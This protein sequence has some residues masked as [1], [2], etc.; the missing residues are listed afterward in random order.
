MSKR[1]KISDYKDII[2]IPMEYKEYLPT[3]FDIIGKII[4]IKLKSETNK[5][6]K[7]IAEALLKTHKNIKSVCKISSVTGELRTRNIEI[8]G[9]ENS[10]ETIHKEYGINY[11]L[12]IKKTYFSPRLANERKRIM[13]LVKEN[14][15][16]IDMFTGVAPFSITI[17]KFAKPKIIYA[18]DKNPDAILYAKK[19]ITKNKLLHK[20]ELIK[21]DS[22][23][24]V[25]ILKNRNFEEKADRIIMNLPFSAYK[26]FKV[27]LEMIKDNGVIHYY[28][29]INSNNINDR[30]N[31]LKREAKLKGF[32]IKDTKVHKIKSYSPREFYIGIDVTAKRK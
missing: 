30:I 20:I 26:F 19:N 27:A 18:I 24:A 13:K 1:E 3:S 14:E 15:I 5:Y 2:S 32:L 7:E 28:D 11:W 25:R 21:A 17:A 22:E 23:N 10:T 31:M 4:L 6:E 29:I 12:D 9:G 8:I 16:I